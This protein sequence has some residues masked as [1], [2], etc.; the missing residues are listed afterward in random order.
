MEVSPEAK[1]GMSAKDMEALG[2]VDGDTVKIVSSNG[3]SLSAKAEESRRALEGTVIVPQHFAA[4]KW[5]GL[6]GWNGDPVKV[7]VEKA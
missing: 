6:V 4:L 2:L 1:A 3:D 7:K 5:N